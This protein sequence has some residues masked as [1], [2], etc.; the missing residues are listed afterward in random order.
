MSKMAIEASASTTGIALGTMHGS[1][2]P[3]TCI[4][5]FSKVSRLTDFCNFAIDGVGL[6][7]TRKIIGIPELIPPSIPPL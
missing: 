7:A 3:I 6:I 1:C 2:R 5:V 4:V